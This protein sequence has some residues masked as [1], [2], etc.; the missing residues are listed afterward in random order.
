MSCPEDAP[1]RRRLLAL[2]LAGTVLPVLPAAA[3][4]KAAKAAA[5]YQDHPKNGAMCGHCQFFIA[6][7]GKA[8]QGM[9]GGA[10]GPGKMADGTCKIVAG[11]ISPMG[12]CQFY[13]AIQ[14]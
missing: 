12:W 5:Q 4:T 11:A 6:K 13:A 10:M 8:G 3:A 7:G 1:D 14:A 2:V 9:M